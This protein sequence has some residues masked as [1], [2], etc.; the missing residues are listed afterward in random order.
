[1][2]PPDTLSPEQILSTLR[3]VLDRIKISQTYADD[4][5]AQLAELREAG[6]IG[7]AIEHHGAKA[8]WTE[9]KGAWAYSSAVDNLKTL[10]EAE[11]VATRKPSSFFWTI[12]AVPS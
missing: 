4:L 7:D 2:T 3:D 9:R 8:T 6:T 12:K 11:G 1:L 5:K 10:E